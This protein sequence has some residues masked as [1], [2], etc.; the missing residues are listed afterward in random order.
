VIPHLQKILKPGDI[1]MTLGA[2]NI[3]ELSH[4]LASRFND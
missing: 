3:G 1:L 2:G 4:K